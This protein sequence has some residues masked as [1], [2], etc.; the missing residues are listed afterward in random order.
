MV[1]SPTPSCRKTCPS[2][3]QRPERQSLRKNCLLPRPTARLQERLHWRLSESKSA[4]N[5]RAGKK[6]PRVRRSED[7]ARK[8]LRRHGCLSKLGGST[9]PRLKRSRKIALGSTDGH[10]QR[11]RDGRSRRR[12]W[13]QPCVE[14]LT[15]VVEGRDRSQPLSM[16]N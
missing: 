14:R 15:K 10:K 3:R 7:V 12:S 4:A 2:R 11:R 1:P 6:K 8:Q 9:P 16:Q 5:L 13:K